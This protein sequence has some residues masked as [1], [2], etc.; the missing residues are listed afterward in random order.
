MTSGRPLSRAE[1]KV[2]ERYPNEWP[3]VIAR[4]LGNK[5]S[6]DNGGYRSTAV[7]R[8][9]QREILARVPA[10]DKEETE[11]K[12]IISDDQVASKRFK[13]GVVD[14]KRE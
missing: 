11:P 14:A 9:Y 13:K 10:A 6:A 12:K 1:K 2:I 4:Y 8:N 3:A 7:V 5:Y